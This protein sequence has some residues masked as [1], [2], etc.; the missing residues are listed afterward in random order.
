MTFGAWA[1]GTQAVFLA[2]VAQVRNR[3]AEDELRSWTAT[4]FKQLWL[5]RISCTLMRGVAKC[6]RYRSRRDFETA[7]VNTDDL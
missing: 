7:G 4:T 2:F 6:I 5:Q 1:E 3:R